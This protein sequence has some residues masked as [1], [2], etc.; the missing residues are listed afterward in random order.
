MKQLNEISKY[1]TVIIVTHDKV[2]L[3]QMDEIIN[4]ENYK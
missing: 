2:L 4:I 3:S 1:K